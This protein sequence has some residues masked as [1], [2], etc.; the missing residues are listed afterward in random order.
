MASEGKWEMIFMGKTEE[1]G[2]ERLKRESF[3]LLKRAM[4]KATHEQS[5][6]NNSREA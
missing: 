1:E 5:M 4:Y 3:V 2:E 6:G